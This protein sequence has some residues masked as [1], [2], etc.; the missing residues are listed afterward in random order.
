MKKKVWLWVQRQSNHP[1]VQK[2]VQNSGYD[3]GYFVLWVRRILFSSVI[4][5]LLSRW[6]AFHLNLNGDL[7]DRASRLSVMNFFVLCSS[8]GDWKAQI[9]LVTMSSSAAAVTNA[10]GIFRWTTFTWW[11][12]SRHGSSCKMELDWI[13]LKA[14]STWL[15]DCW[16]PLDGIA[17]V[18]LAGSCF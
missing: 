6:G 1:Y 18:L 15:S 7:F 10:H 16:G 17:Q 2:K 8:T 13:P 12:E 5:W 14:F 3:C 11:C 4:S 9:W